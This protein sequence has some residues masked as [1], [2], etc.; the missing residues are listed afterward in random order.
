MHYCF[1]ITKLKTERNQ[2]KRDLIQ[3]HKIISKDVKLTTILLPSPL[4]CNNKNQ[5][6]KFNDSCLTMFHMFQK[7]RGEI[8]FVQAPCN[9]NQDGN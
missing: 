6:F 2:Y 7:V 1:S 9:A 4:Y 3:T 5:K 8:G